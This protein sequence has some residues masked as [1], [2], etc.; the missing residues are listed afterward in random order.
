MPVR[1]LAFLICVVPVCQAQSLPSYYIYNLAGNGQ[2]GNAD[3][4]TPTFNHPQGIW[5]DSAS[6]ALFVADTANN[7]VRRVQFQ[8]SQVGSLFVASNVVATRVAGSGQPG[9]GMCKQPGDAKESTTVDALSANI[10]GPQAVASDSQGN[11]YISDTQNNC[12]RML[13]GSNVITYAG[14]GIQ[15]ASGSG[16]GGN[17]LQAT[18]APGPLAFYQQS[19]LLITDFLRVR[20]VDGGIIQTVAGGGQTIPSTT[21]SQSATGAALGDI[22]SIAS[23][24]TNNVPVIYVANASQV[25]K[26]NGGSLEVFPS[27]ANPSSRCKIIR[28]GRTCEVRKRWRSIRWA[29]C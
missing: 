7:L 27:G 28:Q 5:Y 12:V 19:N 2:I 22:F 21:G 11:V 9:V 20:L 15:G 25:F 17:P 18:I 14:N 4:S 8:I 26:V 16:D 24:T 23:T 13:S 29:T 6:H 10:W 1:L 3:G